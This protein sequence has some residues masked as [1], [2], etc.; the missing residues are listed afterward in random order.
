MRIALLPSAVLL[1]SADINAAGTT[2]WIRLV[3][4]NAPANYQYWRIVDVSYSFEE[5]VSAPG[6]YTAT[7]QFLAAVLT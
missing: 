2:C 3:D 7:A 6:T 4:D 1:Q 5:V